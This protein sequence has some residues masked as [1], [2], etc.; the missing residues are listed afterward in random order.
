MQFYAK[1][2]EILNKRQSLEREYV[3]ALSGR[4]NESVSG[5]VP[6]ISRERLLQIQEK[7]VKGAKYRLLREVPHPD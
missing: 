7:L 5:P 3:M 1:D 2:R 4:V 6:E